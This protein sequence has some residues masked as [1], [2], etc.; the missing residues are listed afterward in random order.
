MAPRA[1]VVYADQSRWRV[2]DS[3]NGG[4]TSCFERPLTPRLLARPRVDRRIGELM[5]GDQNGE[6]H[7]W[8][9]HRCAS[10]PPERIAQRRPRYRSYHSCRPQPRSSRLRA[11]RGGMRLRR[12][13]ASRGGMRSRWR[14][15][16]APH[17]GKRSRRP[18]AGDTRRYTRAQ[19][20]ARL[21]LSRRS[22]AQLLETRDTR[23]PIRA[24]RTPTT[25]RE[26]VS[27]QGVF[28]YA[29]LAAGLHMGDF[30]TRCRKPRAASHR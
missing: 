20:S 28:S 22:K 9:G 10:G 2:L 17:G 4:E 21:L 24:T 3:E 14:R 1:T 30:P 26:Q 29:R 6:V 25:P 11:P 7:V 27:K 19:R 8:G 16:R 23:F 15:R 13:R 18:P 12:R 5:A